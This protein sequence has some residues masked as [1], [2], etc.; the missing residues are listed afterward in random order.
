[1]DLKGTP[2]TLHDFQ[3]STES[4]LI[5]EYLTTANLMLDIQMADKVPETN[6]NGADGMF[7]FYG[8]GGTL[9]FFVV[10]MFIY[11]YIV[12]CKEVAERQETE[13][14]ELNERVSRVSYRPPINQDRI[15]IEDFNQTRSTSLTMVDLN[16]YS[17]RKPEFFNGKREEKHMD[18]RIDSSLSIHDPQETPDKNY[19]SEDVCANTTVREILET[20]GA[21]SQITENPSTLGRV[22]SWMSQPPLCFSTPHD[23]NERM[24]FPEDF[25]DLLCPNTAQVHKIESF[26]EHNSNSDIATPTKC[27]KERSCHTNEKSGTDDT[28]P[29]CNENQTPSKS[30]GKSRSSPSSP[31]I[32]RRRI[33]KSEDTSQRPY[34]WQ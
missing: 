24:F 20:T 14:R 33:T 1:M 5:H 3:T 22:E 15:F 31:D 28:L 11:S 4:G 32:V 29:K 7:L 13:L 6:T 26:N 16:S 10:Y 19:F 25:L 18:M 23:S 8:L 12:H 21:V 2:T 30:K 9:I 34:S 27:D 17:K